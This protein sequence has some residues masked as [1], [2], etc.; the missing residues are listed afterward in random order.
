MPKIMKLKPIDTAL[1]Q[2]HSFIL[3]ASVQIM[4]GKVIISCLHYEIC[5]II[6]TRDTDLYYLFRYMMYII[7]ATLMLIDQTLSD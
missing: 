6:L 5:C 4:C 1:V 2:L 3:L 7:R